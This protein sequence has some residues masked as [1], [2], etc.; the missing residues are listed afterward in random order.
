[1]SRTTTGVLTLITIL[2]ATQVIINVLPKRAREE[3]NN[4]PLR[5]GTRSARSLIAS[6]APL[7]RR[8]LEIVGFEKFQ[9]FRTDWSRNNSGLMRMNMLG[10]YVPTSRRSPLV[11]GGWSHPAGTSS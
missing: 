6:D 2:L 4:L 5:L 7:V 1:M 9:V 3:Q 11:F 10:M 8:I